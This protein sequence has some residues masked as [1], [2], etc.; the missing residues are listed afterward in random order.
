MPSRELRHARALRP[1][2]HPAPTTAAGAEEACGDGD[3]LPGQRRSIGPVPAEPPGVFSVG[4]HT[5]TRRMKAHEIAERAAGLV[6]GDRNHTHGEAKRNHANI[7]AFWS[8]YLQARFAGKH[9][10]TVTPHDAAC[11]MA[12]LKIARTLTGAHNSDDYVDAVGYAA[13]AGAIAESDAE[14]GDR[15]EAAGEKND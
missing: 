5:M 13:I 10:I 11:M 7:A 9:C 8:A 4:M 2:R 14:I 15:I 12:L 1:M 3:W 6:S